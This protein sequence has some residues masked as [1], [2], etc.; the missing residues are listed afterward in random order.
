MLCGDLNGK[1]IQKR[2]DMCIRV[3]DSVCC[4]VE[5][6]IVKQLYTNKIFKLFIYLAVQ[7]LSCDTRES[8]I[9]SCS[10]QDLV[11]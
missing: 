5:D 10:P 2:G 11:L 9:F 1:E 8:L 7:G 4:T 3:A 6:N